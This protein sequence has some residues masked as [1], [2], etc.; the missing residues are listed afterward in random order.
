V[1]IGG[2]TPFD[3]KLNS[4]LSARKFKSGILVIVSSLPHNIQASLRFLWE[5]AERLHSI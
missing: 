1:G 3:L 4:N 5:L 2:E